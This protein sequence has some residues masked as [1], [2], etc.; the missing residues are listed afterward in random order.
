MT[1]RAYGDRTRRVVEYTRDGT[2]AHFPIRAAETGGAIHTAL[3]HTFQYEL[4]KGYLQ[5]TP[6][7]LTNEAMTMELPSQ[8]MNR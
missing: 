2:L 7:V 5:L 1:G 8:V 3:L 6:R 4:A